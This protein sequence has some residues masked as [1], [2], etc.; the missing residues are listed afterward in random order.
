M[1]EDCKGMQFI[2]AGNREDVNQNVVFALK[3]EIANGELILF[4][5]DF[6]QVFVNGEFV[7]YGPERTAAG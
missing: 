5:A 4:A 7:C 1:K 3:K 6:Y 2:W